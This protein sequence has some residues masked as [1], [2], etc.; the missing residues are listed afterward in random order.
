MKETRWEYIE[1]VETEGKCQPRNK[2]SQQINA[3]DKHTADWRG[4]MW[5]CLFALQT[6]MRDIFPVLEMR[7]ES[8]RRVTVRGINKAFVLNLL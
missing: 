2:N 5:K 7:M 1:P 8:L 6:R 4:E 3:N